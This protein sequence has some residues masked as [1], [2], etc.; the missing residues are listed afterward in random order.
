MTDQTYVLCFAP[1]TS[2]KFLSN[3]FWEMLQQQDFDWQLSANNTSHTVFLS[4]FSHPNVFISTINPYEFF[5]FDTKKKSDIH[6]N[7]VQRQG[8][9]LFTTHAWPDFDLI[10]SNTDLT[11]TKFIIVTIDPDSLWEIFLNDFFKNSLL[12]LNPHVNEQIKTVKPEWLVLMYNDLFQ[13]DITYDELFP[14]LTREKTEI[15]ARFYYKKWWS[16]N[17]DHLEKTTRPMDLY[18]NPAEIPDDFKHRTLLLEYKDVYT[19]AESEV[20]VAVE[21]MAQFMNQS[22]ASSIIRKR[23][24]D[25]SFFSESVVKKCKLYMQG[26]QDLINNTFKFYNLM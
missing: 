13:T 8:T 26:R 19:M 20:P 17:P 3:I 2:G 15:L 23:K 5:K 10:R 18:Q 16:M 12:T 22:S 14:L 6:G 4:M 9:G 11:H 25:K 7:L 1:G 24:I 21:K